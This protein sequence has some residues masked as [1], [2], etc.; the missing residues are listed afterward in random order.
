LKKWL[1]YETDTGR[2]VCVL[3]VELSEEAP[4]VQNG[5][6]VIAVPEDWDGD[7]GGWIVRGGALVQIVR[8]KVPVEEQAPRETWL[9][10]GGRVGQI[11]SEFILAQLRDDAEEIEALKAEFRRLEARV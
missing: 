9:P 4:E 1:E 6:S 10:F 2:I 3:T 11:M 8:I 7:T 5:H